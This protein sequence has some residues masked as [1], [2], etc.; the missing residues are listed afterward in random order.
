MKKAHELAV[1]CGCEVGLIVINNNS[2]KVHQFSSLDMDHCLLRYASSNDPTESRNNIDFQRF[3]ERQKE[4]QNDNDDKEGGDDDE[5][6]RILEQFAAI[7]PQAQPTNS[8]SSA[9]KSIR[10]LTRKKII[11][12]RFNGADMKLN[13]NLTM[14]NTTASISN[15]TQTQPYGIGSA[16]NI[17]G[18]IPLTPLVNMLPPLSALIQQQP[19]QPSSFQPQMDTPQILANGTGLLQSPNQLSPLPQNFPYP[20]IY[21]ATPSTS[22]TAQPQKPLNSTSNVAEYSLKKARI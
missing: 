18:G 14:P 9:P 13:T 17:F 21:S 20:G 10:E 1:L 16:T 12:Q 2:G 15:F 4:I 3:S 5:D 7:S 11:S 8:S 19:V 6:E 22:Q